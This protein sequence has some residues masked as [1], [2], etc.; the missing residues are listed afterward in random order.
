MLRKLMPLILSFVFLAGCVSS[1]SGLSIATTTTTGGAEQIPIDLRQ[2]A[3]RSGEE[4]TIKHERG[5][6]PAAHLAGGNVDRALPDDHGDR[7]E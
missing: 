1:T 4:P 5:D 2:R 7:A 6:R 3:E